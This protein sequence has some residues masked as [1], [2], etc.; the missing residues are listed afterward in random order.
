MG[1]A[2]VFSVQRICNVQIST[3]VMK[4]DIAGLIMEC[5]RMGRTVNVT[6]DSWSATTIAAF[7]REGGMMI[8]D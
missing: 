5:V 8:F 7:V 6:V 2:R 3:P 4:R 1:I